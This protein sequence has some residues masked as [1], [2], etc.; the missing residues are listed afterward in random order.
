MSRIYEKFVN[1]FEN[2]HSVTLLYGIFAVTFLLIGLINEF[3]ISNNKLLTF[4]I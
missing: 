4:K 1:F 3:K 2:V